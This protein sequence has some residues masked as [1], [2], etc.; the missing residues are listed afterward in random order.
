MG[1]VRTGPRRLHKGYRVVHLK[2]TG[3]VF[4]L[5][6][7]GEGDCV[8]VWGGGVRQESRGW[9]SIQRNDLGCG[10]KTS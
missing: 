6:S 9:V 8:C 3:K 1:P 10:V 7:L 5:I 4:L 2:A